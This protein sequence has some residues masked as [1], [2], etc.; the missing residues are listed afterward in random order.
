M[1]TLQN[2]IQL[3]QRSKVSQIQPLLSCQSMFLKNKNLFL[4]LLVLL[5]ESRHFTENNFAKIY[6][7]E[8]DI[9]FFNL[10]SQLYLLSLEYKKM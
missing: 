1:E 2:L 5:Y 4:E 3:L 9:V 6:S 10:F 7:T 8:I